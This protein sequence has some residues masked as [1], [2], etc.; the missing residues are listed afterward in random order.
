MRQATFFSFS[1]AIVARKSVAR[2]AMWSSM[3]AVSS[4]NSLFPMTCNIG[5]SPL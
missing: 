1:I 4:G 3:P 5:L 2:K